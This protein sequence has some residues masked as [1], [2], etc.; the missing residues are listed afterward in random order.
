MPGYFANPM[1]ASQLGRAGVTQ[2]TA[3]PNL[4]KKSGMLGVSPEAWM[5]IAAA[6]GK[7]AETNSF[8]DAFSGVGQ[9]LQYEKG[10][11]EDAQRTDAQQRATAR[12]LAGDMKGAMAVLASAK[13][14][15]GQ[16]M[17]MASNLEGRE[18]QQREGDRQYERGINRS[19]F[20]Y[21]RGRKDE[22]TDE[23]RAR[24]VAGWTHI[25]DRGE[26]V[27]DQKAAMAH[28]VDMLGRQLAGQ[29]ALAQAKVGNG[30]DPGDEKGLTGEYL[31]QAKTFIDV[32]DAYGRI[33][34]I[35]KYVAKNP[36]PSPASDIS[37]VF[38]YMKMNDPGSTVREGEY[39]T[40]Q[41][42]AGL[43]DQVR[44]VYNKMLTGE[45]LSD[46]QRKD[47]LQAAQQLYTAQEQSYMGTLDQ[48]RGRANRYSM[49][50]AIIQDLRLQMDE[51][52]APQDQVG[53]NGG[54]VT[55]PTQLQGKLSATEAEAW[56]ELSPELQK[57]LW[58]RYQGKPMRYGGRTAPGVKGVL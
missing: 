2:A 47:F 23:Q 17:D 30:I 54:S 31:G 12:M 5:M 8:G 48:Y 42:A 44:N 55:I 35:E 36:Q 18:Y 9:A 57:R 38:N 25:R 21:D 22:L 39:A 40:A 50:P 43:P 3:Q 1:I 7:G 14:L 46:S 53:A 26:Q 6:L 37:L 51:Q 27:K 56:D 58:E 16:A 15:E 4:P 33:R 28:D 20:E 29:R 34:Q 41:N 49:D 52:V 13:G 19:D 32:R 45:T 24:A 10:Q 11:N